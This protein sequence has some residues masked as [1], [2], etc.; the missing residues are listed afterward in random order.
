MFDNHARRRKEKQ[1]RNSDERNE[2]LVCGDRLRSYQRPSE[3]VRYAGRCVF[4]SGR[5]V[6]RNLRRR[7][8]SHAAFVRGDFQRKIEQVSDNRFCHRSY[9]DRPDERIKA[10]RILNIVIPT[11]NVGVIRR[12][13]QSR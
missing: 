6:S 10:L 9:F 3:F 5:S 11:E 4:I 12:F 1:R 8:D 7:V 13:R 2:R